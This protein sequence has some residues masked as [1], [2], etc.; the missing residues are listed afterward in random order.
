M[1]NNIASIQ[2]VYYVFS[3]SR[4]KYVRSTVCNVRRYDENFILNTSFNK[5]N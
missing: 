2:R 3:M 5:D 1:I 4:L